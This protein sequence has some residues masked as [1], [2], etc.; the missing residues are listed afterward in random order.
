MMSMRLEPNTRARALLPSAFSLDVADLALQTTLALKSLLDWARLSTKTSVSP[1]FVAKFCESRCHPVAHAKP[2]PAPISFRAPP[3]SLKICL[4]L[5]LISTPT[6]AHNR[7]PILVRNLTSIL[8]LSLHH[9]PHPF[10]RCVRAGRG[11]GHAYTRLQPR[12]RNAEAEA[13]P[14]Q[15][16]TRLT[17]T[18][19]DLRKLTTE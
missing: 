5:T 9:P 12:E 17:G 19:A 6:L 1:A 3:E 4:R 16:S 14:K 2:A 10:N 8:R 11:E 13:A 15:S 7:A 18:D